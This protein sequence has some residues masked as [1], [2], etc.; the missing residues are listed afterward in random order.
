[1]AGKKRTDSKGRVLKDNEYQR[2]DGQY[3]YR[4]TDAAGKKKYIY[5]WKL[6]PTDKIPAGKR[7][8]LSLREQIK[9][10]TEDKHKGIDSAAKKKYTL[11]DIFDKYIAGKTE[12]KP[13]TRVNYLYMYDQYVRNTIGKR[14]IADIKYSDIKQFYNSLLKGNGD[15]KGF[16]VHSMEIIHT[17]L[18]PTFTL[19]VRDDIILKNPTDNV[20]SEIKRE[21]GWER[22]QRHALTLEQQHLFMDFLRSNKQYNHWYPIFAVMLGTGCRV[23]ELL[24]LQWDNVDTKSGIITIKHN[25]TYR[26]QE[27]SGRLE[28]HIST[29]KTN[30][31][32]RIIP[33]I[34][35]VKYVLNEIRKQQMLHG[36]STIEIDGC[37]GFV[38]LNQNGNPYTSHT[39]NRALERIRLACNAEEA[40]KAEKENRDAVKIPHFSVHN[41]RHTFCTRFCENETNVKVIQEIMGHADISTT[42]NIYAEATESKKKESIAELAAKFSLGSKKAC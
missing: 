33:M 2:P 15:R 14:K 1:M 30:A 31:G 7:D 8:S 10:I 22:P 20:M 34:Q 13:S 32:V 16:Q 36:F 42:M 9:E 39:L 29:P 17:I 4:Y 35:E 23:G 41:L 11:N 24:A 28:M 40:A 19:A 5:S 38:F 25:L 12:L 6:V 21:H 26:P 37:K 3:M 27:G 18:H